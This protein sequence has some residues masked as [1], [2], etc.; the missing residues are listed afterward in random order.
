MEVMMERKKHILRLI[1]YTQA[2]LL[3]FGNQVPDDQKTAVGLVDHWTARDHLAHIAHWKC[4]F[5]HRLQLREKAEKPA[6]DIDKENAKVFERYKLKSWAEVIH[7]MEM[8]DQDFLH[9]VRLISEEDLN[10]TT[11]LP[12]LRERPLWQLLLSDGCTHPLSHIAQVYIEY[13]HPDKAVDIQN[14]IMEDLQSLDDSSKWH[15]TNIYNLACIHALA[16]K[17]DEAIRLL[18]ESLSH[19]P[20]LAEWSR[21]DPDFNGIRDL[22]EYKA[23]Y[24]PA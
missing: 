2:C 12:S 9:Q 4:V 21:H 17:H 20:D 19:Y 7:L 18:K 3:E 6:T 23:L 13:G 22:E 1:S 10:S 24:V 8:A 15:G 5:N 11:I 16:G 14:K